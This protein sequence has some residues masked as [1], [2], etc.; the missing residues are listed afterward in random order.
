MWEHYD[1]HCHTYCVTVLRAGAA[2][3][4][5]SAVLTSATNRSVHKHPN[6]RGVQHGLEIQPSVILP[7]ALTRPDHAHG[8]PS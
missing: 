4:E 6:E 7:S 3:V 2:S 8:S 5:K 1:L